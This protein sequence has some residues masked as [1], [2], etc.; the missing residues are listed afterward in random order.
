MRKFFDAHE[1][2]S[3]IAVLVPVNDVMLAIHRIVQ[4]CATESS[5]LN[6]VIRP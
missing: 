3:N 6:S 1:F 4:W 2:D 5:M